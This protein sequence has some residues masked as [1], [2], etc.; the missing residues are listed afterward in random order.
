MK[1][2][3]LVDIHDIKENLIKFYPSREAYVNSQSYFDLCDALLDFIL[4]TP[5]ILQDCIITLQL[6]KD[7]FEHMCNN[8]KA[9][10]IRESWELKITPEY[11][12]RYVYHKKGKYA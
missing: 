7:N 6:A 9:P 12:S 4:A 2:S 11:Q 1:K 3:T 8:T 5:V 10:D